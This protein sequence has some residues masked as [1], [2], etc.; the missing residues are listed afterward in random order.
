MSF[1][2]YPAM[3]LIEGRCVRLYKG[4]FDQKTEYDPTPLELIDSY[5]EQGAEYLH[6]VDLDGAKDPENRQVECL[7]QILEATKLKVQVGGGV[8][9]VA[10]ALQLIELGADKLVIG[11]LAVKDWNLTKQIIQ[12]VGG[13]NITIGVDVFVNEAQETSVAVSGWQK[14][15][16]MTAEELIQRYSDLGVT[17]F[18]CTDIDKDGTLTAPNFSLYEKL[19][20]EFSKLSILVSGGISQLSDIDTSKNLGAGGVIIG[21]ALFE[22]KFTLEEALTC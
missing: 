14:K 5:E 17:Q 11:S 1:K 3:D 2:I 6:V 7:T 16:Q 8:R 13:Q 15:S 18:L 21:K 9:T 10:D 4:D 22:G 20:Q 19:N 12:S